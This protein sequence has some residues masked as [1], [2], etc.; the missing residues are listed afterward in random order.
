MLAH[1]SFTSGNDPNHPCVDTVLPGTNNRL[2]TYNRNM[3]NMD[4]NV[5]QLRLEFKDY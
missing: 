3:E 1:I 5:G 4:I 2:D